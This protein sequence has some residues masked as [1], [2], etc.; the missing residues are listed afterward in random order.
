MKK[1]EY[2]S[3]GIM[4]GTSL[5]G[6]DFSLIKTDGKFS[7]KTLVNEYY[8]F[9]SNFKKSIKKL[10]K[11]IDNYDSKSIRDSEEF[12]GLDQK[13]SEIVLKRIKDFGVKYKSKMKNLDVIGIHGNTIIHQPKYGISIQLGKPNFLCSNLNIA[14]V[15]DF[16][17]NDIKLD[18][19]GA[20]LVPI[21]HKSQFSEKKKNIMVVNIGG[22]TN[23]T[24]LKGKTKIFAS[25]IGPG[26]KLIDEFCQQKF[27][28]NFD[29]RG[30]LAK[31]GR[32]LEDLFKI[33]KN[34]PFLKFPF[35]ISF[36]NSFFKLGEFLRENNLNKFDVLRTLTYFT[37]FQFLNLKLR[38]NVNIDK[39]IFSGGGVKNRTLMSDIKQLLSGEIVTTTLNY[40]LN[41]FFIESQA[42]AY[43]AVRTLKKLPS[44][45]PSTT[46]C[47]KSSASGNIYLPD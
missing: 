25:D 43:I 10:I 33:W 42:F 26:N 35:P 39:W 5:D 13:F 24:L 23:F 12:L 3:L 38:I 28:K 19:Q 21:F 4:S 45:F 20:P 37:A 11:K 7:I 16:R 40:K 6:L 27:D 34:K 14:I 32:L 15:S 47:L 41:P 31:N 22:I 36:D 18:G 9:N 44:S 2:C 30:D 8:E 29:N 1:K 17:D 46:G